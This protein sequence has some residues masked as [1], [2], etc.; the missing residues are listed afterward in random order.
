MEDSV[1]KLSLILFLILLSSFSYSY[2]ID[3]TEGIVKENDL[4][5]GPDAKN[6]NLI[7]ET[8]FNNIID[9]VVEVYE[10]IIKGHN[11]KLI[12][13]KKWESGTVNAYASR[14]R[15]KWMIHMFG[16]LARH[17]AITP[18]AFALVVCHEIGH[19]LGGAPKKTKSYGRNGVRTRWATTEGQADYWATLKCLRKT[20]RGENHTEAL[21]SIEV[22]KEVVDS[23]NSQFSN[24]EDIQICQRGAMAGLSTAKLFQDLRDQDTSPDFS[25]PDPNVVTRSFQN[26][27]ATQ[28]R[29]DTY[30]QGAL[31]SLSEFIDVDQENALVGNCNRSENE[32]VGIRPLCWFKPE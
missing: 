16:G 19:H 20:W 24:I 9:K 6:I 1:P 12:V 18:D 14:S 15:N 29:L 28:C 23:C 5:I 17:S 4:W 10:P 11:A 26:H 7:D 3:G 27:P 25:T 32:T 30:F 2:T 13:K 8:L 31:C 21:A 22:P